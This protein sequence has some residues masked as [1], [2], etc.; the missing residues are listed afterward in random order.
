MGGN[1]C[2]YKFIA[3]VFPLRSLLIQTCVFQS[4]TLA[5]SKKVLPLPNDQLFNYISLET[6]GC[7]FPS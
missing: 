7:H 5:F 6:P 1:N 3:D 2:F 4:G